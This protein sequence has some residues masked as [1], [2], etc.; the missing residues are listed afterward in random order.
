MGANRANPR[1]PLAGKKPRAR[2]GSDGRPLNGPAGIAQLADHVAASTVRD[3]VIPPANRSPFVDQLGAV[4][5]R[6]AH[7]RY[8]GPRGACLIPRKWSVAH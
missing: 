8:T 6:R 5:G 2:S 4:L 3:P 1:P 7:H